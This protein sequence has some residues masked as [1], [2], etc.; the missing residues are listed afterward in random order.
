MNGFIKHK[1]IFAVIALAFAAL[2]AAMLFFGG[3]KTAA[4]VSVDDNYR[5]KSINIDI[6]VNRDKT[7]DIR[8]T[9]E[10]EFFESGINTGIIRDIQRESKTTRIIDCKNK[11]GRRY[12]A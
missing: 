12:I 10:A 9:L 8:E 4:A 7:F 2:C 11:A 3:N 1:K 6:S 5:F